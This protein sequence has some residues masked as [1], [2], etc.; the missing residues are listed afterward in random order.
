MKRI[1]GIYEKLGD[2]EYFIPQSLP[3]I[4]PPLEINTE[5]LQLY[6]KTMLELGKLNEISKRIPDID[7]FV[8]AY[9]KKEAMLSS[10]IENIHTTLI[11]MYSNQYDSTIDKDTQLV[12]NYINA[13]NN[14]TQLL[15]TLPISN[16]IIL[17]SH[18]I[19]MGETSNTSGP[20]MYREQTVR[21]GN[22]V[23]PPAK[24]IHRLMSEWEQFIHTQG[25]LP[26]LI[27]NGLAHVQFETIH[28]FL[29]G[30]GR[31][32]RLLI[33]LM[34]IESGLLK[35]PIIYPS[36]YFKKNKLQY[37]AALDRVRTHGDFEG[38]IYFFLEAI[39]YS[40]H[41]A[42][43]R[44][45]EI[46]LLEQ[47]LEAIINNK[48]TKK[49][50]YSLIQALQVIFKNPII[51]VSQLA[52]HLEKSYNATTKLIHQLIELDILQE[53]TR[54]KRNKLYIFSAYLNILN[55]EY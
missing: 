13:I 12:L 22:L 25:G 52:T 49:N 18:E 33:V 21:V 17:K 15:D 8:N 16:R 51:N 1:T 43:E 7:R 48:Y 47:K 9:V 39:Y 41:D 32:G 10:E 2:L 31:M 44:A 26:D 14:A 55:K 50:C 37:Y 23:P 46:E 54:Q 34:L 53:H 45:H 5:L 30:N 42:L 29:D 11:E 24:A 38:W 27:K 20:G 35:L 28:P 19:L 36:Y 3:P 6:G 40:A 4:E